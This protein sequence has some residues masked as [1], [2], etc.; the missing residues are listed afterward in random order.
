MQMLKRFKSLLGLFNKREKR[1]ALILLILIFIGGIVE[2]L[3]IGVIL[4]FTTVLLDQNSIAAYP[5]LQSLSEVPWIGGYRRFVVLMCVLL[6]LIFIFKS[7]YMFFLIYVQNRFIRNRHVELTRRLFQSYIYKPYEYFFKKNT[8][9]LQRNVNSLVHAAVNGL[10]MS[11]L[12]LLTEL[13]V[14]VFILT[15]LFIIDPVSTL[16]ITVVLGGTV[17]LIYHVLKNKLSRSAVKQNVHGIN[18]VKLV[19]EGLGCIKDIK[20]LGRESNFLSS[21]KASGAIYAKQTAFYNLV[22]Q[23]PRLLIETIA[24]S[25]LILIVVINTLRSPDM[26]AALPVIALFGMAAIRVMPSL[27]RIMQQITAIRYNSVFFDRIYPDLREATNKQFQQSGNQNIAPL[28]FEEKIE[29]SG[30]TYRYPETEAVVLDDVRLSI[31]RGEA[32]GIVGSSGAGKTTFVDILLGLLMPEKGSILVDGADIRDNLA[33]WRKNIGYVPQHIFIVDDTVAA[34]VALG[35]S[36]DKIDREKVWAALETANLKSFV[37]SLADG[38]DTVVGEKG[39]RFSGGQQQRLG[40]AR[41]LYDNPDVLVLDEATSALDTESEKVISE[42]IAAIGSAKTMV[43]IAHRLNTLEKCDTIYKVEDGK[44][45]VA[46][47]R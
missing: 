13:V 44:M 30:L 17:L 33:A 4:P 22:Q 8:A 45:V 27:N 29:I 16:G 18:M 43:I 39:V 5:F 36:R 21:Y 38:A 34:N 25:G 31:A 41:A 3:G 24:V 40:I 32:V 28:K 6:I 9:E 12:S 26:N 15:L 20:V 1:N 47:L 10:F 35:V 37:L 46:P 19:N 2:T 7:V 14:I 11:G 42:A 23:A